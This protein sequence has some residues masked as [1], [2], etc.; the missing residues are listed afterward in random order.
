MFKIR[1]YIVG[2]VVHGFG[3]HLFRHLDVFPRGTNVTIEVFHR[4]FETIWDQKKRLPKKFYIQVS[5][6]LRIYRYCFC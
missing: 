1:Q 3:I 5:E 2:V 6:M 4:V